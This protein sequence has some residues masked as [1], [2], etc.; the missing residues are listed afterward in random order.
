MNKMLCA[1]FVICTALGVS[2]VADALTVQPPLTDLELVPGEEARETV[3]LVNDEATPVTYVMSVEDFT[4]NG[5]EGD[6]VFGIREPG[7]PYGLSNWISFPVREVTL[8]PDERYA[9]EYFVRIPQNPEPGGHYGAV[10]FGTKA[11]EGKGQVALTARIAHLILVNVDGDV[12]EDAEIKGFWIE[13]DG[14]KFFTSIP[15]VTTTRFASTGNT[16]LKP[17]GTVK[18]KGWFNEYEAQFNKTLNNVLPDSV[19]RF[20]THIGDDEKAEGFFG[21]VKHQLNRF[22]IGPYK[23]APEIFYGK[24]NTKVQHLT[25]VPPIT[26]WMFPWQLIVTAFV[27]VAVVWFIVKM[28]NKSVIR[29]YEKKKRN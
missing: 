15:L 11:E 27:I 2:H 18:M 28:Y 5:E 26:V 19:R 21:N 29:G 20:E 9:F 22:A 10:F 4:A 1:A 23:V 3:I 17:F 12:V 7:E 14:K 16:H 24:P 8:Q 13:P 6:P 25:V